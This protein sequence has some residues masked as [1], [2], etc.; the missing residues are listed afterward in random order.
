MAELIQAVRGMNDVLP[1]DAPAWAF[2]E[3]SASDLLDGYGYT[4]IR[5]PAVE[6]TELF[7]RSIGEA[8]DIVE[9]EMYTFE[10]RN[11]DSLTLRPEATAGIARAGLSH[12]LFHNQQQRL[13]C[14]GPMFRHEKPQKA[15]Y[16]QFHQLSVEAVG[17]AGPEIDAE[18]IA[19]SARLWRALGLESP[20]LELNSLG[21]PDSRAH[22]REALVAYL[23]GHRDILDA[24]SRRRLETNPLRILDSK[25]P[26]LAELIAAAPLLADFLD[27]ESRDHFERVKQLLAD[28]GIEFVLNPRLVRG[29]DYYSRTVFEWVTDRLGAQGAI[30]SGGRYDGLISQLG[31]RET[32]ASGWALGFERVVE[33]LAAEGAEIPEQLPDAYFVTVG[34]AARRRA[35]AVAETLRSDMPDLKL[36]MDCTAGGFKAQLRRADRSGA[37]LALIIGEDE[38]DSGS[39]SVK[40]LRS[41]VAQKIVKLEELAEALLREAAQ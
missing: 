9:K 23:S 2:V 5:T 13:W 20:T 38:L 12:G 11:G 32:P 22:Y 33:L 37:R 1:G 34:D 25:N 10:D 6:R 41:D 28:I 29:L 3:S 36:A 16:R 30:C 7:K 14:S 31:G 15:R 18:L 17:F 24:D 39:V 35:F 21:T 40:P 19:I 26:A 8:T 27:A 4:R